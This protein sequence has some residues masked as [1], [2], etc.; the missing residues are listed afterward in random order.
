M[1]CLSNWKYSLIDFSAYCFKF[2]FIRNFCSTNIYSKVNITNLWILQLGPCRMVVS[3]YG[4]S[5]P[6]YYNEYMSIFGESRALNVDSLFW[7]RQVPHNQPYV[8][9]GKL[10]V[11]VWWSWSLWQQSW[12]LFQSTRSFDRTLIAYLLSMSRRFFSWLDTGN[13][14]LTHSFWCAMHVRF[15]LVRLWITGVTPMV[16]SWRKRQTWRVLLVW[17]TRYWN[18]FSCL[19]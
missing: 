12:L 17:S 2:W 6:R 1:R 16:F 18:L 15:I 14:R 11:L 10:S 7:G 8:I 5:P 9:G 19:E 4:T 13:A 3:I